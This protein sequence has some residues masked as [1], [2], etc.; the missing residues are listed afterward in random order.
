MDKLSACGIDEDHPIWKAIDRGGGQAVDIA[1][2]I[3]ALEAAGYVVVPKEPT[4]K[5]LVDGSH[6]HHDFFSERGPYPRTRAAYRAMI[7]ARPA[8][9]G[10][11]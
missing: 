2:V 11:K 10:G 4:E 6:R 9:E 1:G 7:A 8:A 3:N 5:M